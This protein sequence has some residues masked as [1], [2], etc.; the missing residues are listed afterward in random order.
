MIFSRGRAIVPACVAVAT[1]AL[2]AC[3]GGHHQ[4]AATSTTPTPTPTPTPSTSHVAAPAVNPFTGLKPSNHGV[5]AVKIDDTENGRP[6]VNINQADLVFVEQVEGGLTRLLA[7]YDAN[8][9][10]VEAVRSTRASD[11]ELL[12]QFG[13]IAYV[14]SGGGGNPL[15]V[16]D[17]SNLKTTINDRGGPGFSRDPGRPAPYNLQ[18]NLSAVVSA[19]KPPTARSIGFTWAAS[20]PALRSDPAAHSVSTVVG[21]TPV[22]FQWD[23]HLGKFDRYIDGVRQFTA[24]GVP[25]STPN[26]IVEFC[27]VTVYPQDVDVDGNPSQYTHSVG[28]GKVAVF[29]NGR[30]VDGTWSRPAVTSGTT[31]KDG[32]GAPIT[33]APGGAWIILVATG[34]PLNSSA[35]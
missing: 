33:L 17:H 21:G 25:I 23:A 30:R 2:A 5:V 15:E 20:V 10:T 32:H 29:R 11:P 18:S 6:Q 1:V 7:V 34:A 14:A 16:M 8:L 3:S 12:G 35:G 13:P 19:L 22:S 27:K 9:P 4:P 24:A 28:S 31:L 26:V